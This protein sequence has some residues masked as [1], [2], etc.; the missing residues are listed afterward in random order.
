MKNEVKKNEIIS[1]PMYAFESTIDKAV[2]YISNM[3]NFKAKKIEYGFYKIHVYYK[4]NLLTWI[5]EVPHNTNNGVAG[6]ASIAF[7]RALT[8]DIAVE[9]LIGFPFA[10]TISEGTVSKEQYK[11]Y[12]PTIRFITNHTML[13]DIIILGPSEQCP[14]DKWPEY[15]AILDAYF[16]YLPGLVSQ[17]E[18]PKFCEIF[19]KEKLLNP[20]KAFLYTLPMDIRYNQL[21]DIALEIDRLMDAIDKNVLKSLKYNFKD[22]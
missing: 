10:I 19:G 7:P 20:G 5:Q 4:E 13:V 3:D 8:Y 21:G 16:K 14:I 22:I 11:N 9:K 15:G 17:I 18:A 12:V 6:K 2:A 1:Y